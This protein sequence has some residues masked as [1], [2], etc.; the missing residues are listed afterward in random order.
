MVGVRPAGCINSDRN[1]K[2]WLIKRRRRKNT[3]SRNRINPT[4][5]RHI[6]SDHWDTKLDQPNGKIKTQRLETIYVEGGQVKRD[7]VT[8]TFF[9]NGEYMDSESCEIICN[10]SK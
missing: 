2:K 10:A 6:N 4:M 1:G 9:S 7:T 8:R 5:K 3:E